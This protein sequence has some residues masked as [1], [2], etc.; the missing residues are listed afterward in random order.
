M[1]AEEVE[2][3]LKNTGHDVAWL[4]RS[5]R[6][7]ARRCGWRCEVLYEVEGWPCLALR[8]GRQQG[9][10]WYFSAGIHGDEP[11]PPL[12]LLAWAQTDLPAFAEAEGVIFP[13]LNPW[14]L[15][16]NSRTNERGQDLN[17]RWHHSRHPQIRAVQKFLGSEQ[18]RFALCLHEDFDARGIYLYEPWLVGK[19]LR[20]RNWGAE[21]LGAGAQFLPI[22]SRR[23]ID[24]RQVN[25][26]GHFFREVAGEEFLEMGWPEAIYL[27]F[28]HAT[29]SL[30]FETPSERDLAV[31]V[32]AHVAV[33][34]KAVQ[35]AGEEAATGSK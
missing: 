3:W 4:V 18:F 24:G 17:R 27:A 12:A 16:H 35:L 2:Q 6:S 8:K 11:A 1:K 34:Q 22:D 31:R 10:G 29:R 13:C 33:I 28:R 5:W 32:A 20:G 9:R 25:R 15:Q 30:T 26:R 14:G 23:E 19:K 21:L 7:V